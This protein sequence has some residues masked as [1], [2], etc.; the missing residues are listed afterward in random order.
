MCIHNNTL[1]GRRF[2]PRN[3]G[4]A[5]RGYG[6]KKKGSGKLSEKPEPTSKTVTFVPIYLRP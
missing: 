5:D 3:P 4:Y 1:K 6:Q 2:A